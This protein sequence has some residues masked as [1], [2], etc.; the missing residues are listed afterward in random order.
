MKENVNLLKALLLA[1]KT[2]NDSE[3]AKTFDK[4][5]KETR[6]KYKISK[7]KLFNMVME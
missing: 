2:F 7:L 1:Y 3:T 6:I 5:F 4:L